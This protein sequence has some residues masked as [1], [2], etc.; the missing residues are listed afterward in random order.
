MGKT[1]LELFQSKAVLVATQSPEQKYDVRNSKEHQNHVANVL[2]DTVSMPI[3]QAA[4]KKFSNRTAETILEE[5]TTGLRVLRLVSSPII[6]GTDIIRLSTHTTPMKDEMVASANTEG[7]STGLL[8]KFTA[9]VSMVVNKLQSLIGIP[10]D[11]IPTR[12]KLNDEFAKSPAYNYSVVL[13]KIKKDATGSLLGKFLKNNATGTPNQIGKQVLGGAITLAK[14]KVSEMLKGKPKSVVLPSGKVSSGIT[15][16]GGRNSDGG[17]SQFEGGAE[18]PN[19]AGSKVNHLQYADKDTNGEIATYSST[20]NLSGEI[21]DR[22]DLST[23]M[24]ICTNGIL[25]NTIEPE[26]IQKNKRTGEPARQYYSD[27]NADAKGSESDHRYTK[28]DA[29]ASNKD[30]NLENFKVRSTKGGIFTVDDKFVSEDG[31]EIGDSATNSTDF[32]PLIFRSVYKGTAVQFRATI[33]G[34]SE[35]FSPSWDS[36]AFIGSPFQYYTYNS[37]ERAVTFDFKVFSRN[38]SEH[39]NEWDRLHFLASL[40][41]PQG[42][43]SA[44]AIQP[45]II[46][47]TLGDMHKAK[48]GFIESL[49][50]AVDDATPWEIGISDGVDQNYDGSNQRNST[51]AKYRAPKIINVSISIKFLQSKSS[52][53][54]LYSFNDEKPWKVTETPATG[55]RPQ[56]STRYF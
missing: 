31:K 37:I 8:T 3:Q 54:K 14:G 9:K 45:P 1:L 42:Y 18:Y 48:Y 38:E 29:N 36:A 13:P 46:Q 22:N 32:I 53:S 47:F 19:Y 4:R 56:L 39:M 49:S 23:L 52:T 2:V 17:G 33:S 35:T 24:Q 27:V 6:Y 11:I 25:P 40:V 5:E 7:G 41:Y 43:S 15:V 30:Y 10:M 26:R 20:I 12:L 28:I 50:F 21:T 34:Y 55:N 44:G 16:V 51:I